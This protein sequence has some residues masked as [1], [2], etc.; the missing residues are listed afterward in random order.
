[1]PCSSVISPIED[2][3]ARRADRRQPGLDGR[4]VRRP[5]LTAKL[6]AMVCTISVLLIGIGSPAVSGAE[7][8]PQDLPPPPGALERELEAGP[9]NADRPDNAL[10]GGANLLS[11]PIEIPF[12]LEG[13]HL[14]I[15][16]SINGG[17]Q[18]PFLL[19]TGASHLITPDV[20]QD[21]KAATADAARVRGIGSKI[22]Y[23]QLIRDQRISIGGLELTH[24]TVGVSDIPNVILDRGSRPRLAGLIGAEFLSHHAITIDYA[25]RTL[26]L[27]SPGYKPRSAKFSLPLGLSMLPDGFGHPSI[28][29][30]VDGVSGEFVIDTGA[31]GQILLSESFEQEHQPFA[32]LGKILNFISA[33]GIGG[34][35][36]ISMA[37]S[38]EVGIGATVIPSPIISGIDRGASHM[39]RS[40]VGAAGLIGNGML[41]NFIVT[42]DVGASRA[43]FEP[44]AN[45][46][47]PTTLYGT[48]LILD[49][50]EHDTFEVIDVLKDTAAERA[51][52]R[53]GDRLIAIGSQPARDL[54]LADVHNFTSSSQPALTILTADHRRLELSYS[55]LLP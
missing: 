20:A 50:P 40:D 12:I 27:N 14:I 4:R 35:A 28:A 22:S 41:A 10:A 47:H 17:P 31:G 49:K 32:K 25:R 54:G 42:I 2:S 38:K 53:R 37:F 43:Y 23:M 44:V 24:Q 51:G 36:G 8:K 1:M 6:V 26:T 30:E 3:G 16:A 21:L 15:E 34:H 9:Q 7:P 29:A 46:P 52:L 13:S 18:R 5:G 45:R 11:Q 39:N 33:G 48:G 55:R 19:D